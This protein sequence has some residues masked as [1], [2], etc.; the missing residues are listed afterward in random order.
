MFRAFNG[1]ILLLELA[2]LNPSAIP[3]RIHTMAI[4]SNSKDIALFYIDSWLKIT[5]VSL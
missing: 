5:S 3:I 2:L 1:R 4:L